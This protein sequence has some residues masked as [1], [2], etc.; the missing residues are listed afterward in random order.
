MLMFY[1][2]H[3]VNA[4]VFAKTYG[5]QCIGLRYFNVFGKRQDPNGASCP[6]KC[7]CIFIF[8]WNAAVIPLWVKNLI[9]HERPVI[10][11]DGTYSRD[12]TYIDNVIQANEKAL[13][14]PDEQFL[15][16]QR[17]YRN[18]SLAGLFIGLR[19]YIRRVI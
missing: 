16:G 4:D 2:F 8:H 10:N 14:T 15:K 5:M 6:V 18:S 13:F 12:F 9:N 17:E 19:V 3:G 1:L 11:G 7:L